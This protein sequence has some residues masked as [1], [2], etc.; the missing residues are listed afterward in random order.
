MGFQQY[1]L[2]LARSFFRPLAGNRMNLQH[3]SKSVGVMNTMPPV[4]SSEVKFDQRH[5]AAAAA[6]AGMPAAHR[7]GRGARCIYSSARSHRSA[8]H[9]YDHHQR[10]H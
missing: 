10:R 7:R 8:D 3:K 4:T 9:E 1:H 2:R 5:S 6:A